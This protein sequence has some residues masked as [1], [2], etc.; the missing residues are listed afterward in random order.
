M[1]L[2]K[3]E[4]YFLNKFVRTANETVFG[5]L[6]TCR[7]VRDLETEQERTSCDQIVTEFPVKDT[8]WFLVV[9]STVSHTQRTHSS[10]KT[11]SSHRQTEATRGKGELRKYEHN[12]IIKCN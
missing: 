6:L 7:S 10:T 2:K 3:L 1:K 5:K 9:M 8:K 11:E 4:E 12:S